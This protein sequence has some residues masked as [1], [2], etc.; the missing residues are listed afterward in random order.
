MTV[1]GTCYTLL[2][3]LLPGLGSPFPPNQWIIT[4]SGECR[5]LNSVAGPF[6]PPCTPC[7]Q[8]DGALAER[9]LHYGLNRNIVHLCTRTRHDR[10]R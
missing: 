4:S 7:D 10:N 2:Y 8:W 5:Q 9:H 1:A 6:L 3:L